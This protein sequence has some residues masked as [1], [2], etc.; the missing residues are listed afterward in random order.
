[1]IGSTQHE[2]YDV[3][4]V[5]ASLAGCTAATLLARQGLSVALLERKPRPSAY[6]R[7]C[8]HFI[9]PCGTPTLQR[10]GLSDAIEGA[11][12]IRNS[13]DI[14]SSA[15][16]VVGRHHQPSGEPAYGYTIRREKLDPMLRALAAE[17]PG[18]DLLPGLTVTRLLSEHGRVNG[19]VARDREG[20]R[21]ERDIRA[22]LVVAADGRGSTVGGLAGVRSRSRS[23]SRFLYFAYYRDLRLASAPAGQMWFAEPDVAYAYPC[24]DGLTLVACALTRDRLE[25]FKAAPEIEFARVFA[26]L[27]EAPALEG[28]ERTSPLIGKL[29]MPN[30][31]R[32]AAARG[33]AFTGDA[34]LAADPMW[35]VGCGWALQS[36]EWLADHAGPA[37]AGE[38][39]LDR[40]LSRYRR[41]HRRRLLAHHLVCA[42]YSSGR[43][44][45]PHER[46]FL[47][48]GVYDSVTANRLA[49]FGE[50]MI[51]VHDM[52]SPRSVARAMRA[53]AVA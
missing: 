18:V 12:G 23:N 8:T 6:K 29:D 44:L 52:F 40:A 21:S 39:K 35:A 15:G 41:L 28:G 49:G 53:R 9:Q 51:G 25:A 32:P 2:G 1:V 48:A 45:L 11:G 42:S 33:V 26:D 27:P 19:L 20:D 47:S 7:V 13:L 30:A 10:L 5:G 43:R 36:A 22:Q 16:W 34:A 4:V 38:G 3:A 31:H 46:L 14:W 24:D 17:T 37:L 50:R